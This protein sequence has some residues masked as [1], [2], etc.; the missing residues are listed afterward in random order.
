ME[1][2]SNDRNSCSLVVISLYLAES[3]MWKSLSLLHQPGLGLP[4]VSMDYQ[5]R[6]I[7]VN[8]TQNQELRPGV[9]SALVINL[10][11]TSACSALLK[12]D[13]T[14]GH[15]Y[16]QGLFLIRKMGIFCDTVMLAKME[17]LT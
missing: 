11:P 16:L 10:P 5:N 4:L 2:Q 12:M 15:I 9:S 7:S 6:T 14:D 13:L 1:N 17:E 8:T 3:D